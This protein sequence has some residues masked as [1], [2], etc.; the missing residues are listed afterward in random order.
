MWPHSQFLHSCILGRFIYSPDWSYF[1]ISSLLYCMRQL[2]VN[3]RS[4]E[5]VR[6]VLP[7]RGWRQFPALP[8]A[9]AVEPRVHINNQLMYKFPYWKITDHK[10]KQLIHVVN[11][12][13]GLKVN[14]IP[15][16]T[17]ILDFHRS[18]FAVYNV[19]ANE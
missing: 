19:V 7:S 11:L 18:S 10:S 17:F 9:P 12:L 2:S 6:E 13:F 4:G 3:R 14:E 5:K 1:G 15:N 8:S 16:K